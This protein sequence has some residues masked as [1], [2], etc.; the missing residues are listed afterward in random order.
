MKWKVN[1][2]V[3]DQKRFRQEKPCGKKA[4]RSVHRHQSFPRT[5]ERQLNPES[6]C[7]QEVD[8]SCF[9]FLEVSRGYLG[10]FGQLIL[11]QPLA[12]TLTANVRAKDPDSFPFSLGD[13]HDILHRV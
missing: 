6:R 2:P 3:R 7:Q 8:F 10:L 9:N 4:A 13:C 11:S 12:H 1:A 5:A